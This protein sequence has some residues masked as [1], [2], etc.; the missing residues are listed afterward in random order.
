MYSAIIGAIAA[1]LVIF[2]I[3]FLV[4]MKADTLPLVR[5]EGFADARLAPGTD[6]GARI[7]D[8]LVAECGSDKYH[9]LKALLAKMSAFKI[10]L[11]S[12]SGTIDATMYMPLIAT[13]DREQVA[14]TVGRCHAKTIPARELD[15]I[16]G[17]WKER[18]T[19]LIAD[20]AAPEQAAA[21]GELFAGA[22]DDI[23]GVASR[24]CIA[25]APSQ[26]AVSPRDYV[27]ITPD[28]GGAA[29]YVS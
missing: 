20:L 18:G 12:A 25:A 17:L 3:A 7:L 5:E 11:Q 24:Q 22:W 21:L 1:I 19:E 14:Q 8:A 29:V 27:G 15:I 26:K 4:T 10:D 9:E 23:Y 28:A 13:Q 6:G 2:G 16:L